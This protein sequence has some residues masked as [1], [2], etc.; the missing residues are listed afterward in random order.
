MST[1]APHRLPRSAGY[2]MI[3][4]GL[5]VTALAWLK[6]GLPTPPCV[7]HLLTGQPCLTCGATRMVAALSRLDLPTAVRMN[8]LVFT[9][10]LS[11]GLYWIWD[12]RREWTT[13]ISHDFWDFV[14]AR[15][16]ALRWGLAAAAALNWA[17]LIW[18]GR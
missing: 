4:G 10:F 14:F 16:R 18:D 1:A 13:G 7:F 11:A 6:V 3:A 17:F 15:R 2:L 5:A 8:P 12:A 9:L